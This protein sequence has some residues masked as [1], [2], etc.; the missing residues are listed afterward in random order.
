[1]SCALRLRRRH[2][3]LALAGLMAAPTLG[4]AATLNLTS[5]HLTTVATC[6]LIGFPTTSGVDIDTYADQ[7]APTTTNGTKATINV[8]SNASKNQ[9]AYIKFDLTKCIFAP[10]STVIVRAAWLELFVNKLA[11]ACRTEDVFALG[12]AW[13]DTTLTWNNQPSPPGTTLNN[14]PSG[15]R[16]ASAA[17]GN[18]SACANHT[19]NSYVSFDVTTD[20]STFVAGT[21]TNH[22][23]MIRDDVEDSATNQQNTY[24]SLDG[25]SD[26]HAPQLMISYTLV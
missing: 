25:N 9:R 6:A 18:V 23:W 11:P 14:P 16:S 22:G 19:N 15:N 2:L 21:S 1:M 5:Q 17:V 12:S 20:V 26:I 8:Q 7:N 13:S 3:V 4:R 10:A 24:V